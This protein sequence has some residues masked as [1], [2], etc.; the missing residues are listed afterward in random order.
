MSH[1]TT[2]QSNSIKT[3]HEW[4]LAGFL[5][6]DPEVFETL[7]GETKLFNS[8]QIRP[9]NTNIITS[10]KQNTDHTHASYK[11]MRRN[12]RTYGAFIG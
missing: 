1:T 12:K 8:K 3:E 9:F 11:Q 6:K 2:I 7:A 10:V 5:P 4:F